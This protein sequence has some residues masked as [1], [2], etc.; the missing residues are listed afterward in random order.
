TEVLN[1]F[2]S[3]Q[4]STDAP[5]SGNAH[6]ASLGGLLRPG[7]PWW[8]F[9]FLAGEILFFGI[10]GLARAWGWEAPLLGGAALG[11]I[12]AWTTPP[13]LAAHLFLLRRLYRAPPSEKWI[14]E[15]FSTIIFVLYFF[16]PSHPEF[17][18][19]IPLHIGYDVFCWLKRDGFHAAQ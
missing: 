14:S 18:F 2:P 8:T 10:C 6:P 3:L 16:L 1:H 7:N 19:V 11:S 5:G 15:I 9:G 13:Y 12:L 17:A 4:G